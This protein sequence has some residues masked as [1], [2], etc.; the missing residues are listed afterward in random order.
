MH[1]ISN[2]L[3]ELLL[4]VV[5]NCE[6]K[7]ANSGVDMVGSFIFLRFLSPA[8]V[9]PQN[10]NLVHESP[11]PEQTRTLII[12][13]KSLQS[14]IT[15]VPFDGSKEQYMTILD[16]ELQIHNSEI[17]ADIWILLSEKVK[18]KYEIENPILGIQQY[19][20]SVSKF[21]YYYSSKI[22]ESI[23]NE[24]VKNELVS[25]IPDI[26]SKPLYS[27]VSDNS[28][29]DVTSDLDSDCFSPRHSIHDFE[30]IFI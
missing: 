5:R 16:K 18:K 8:I 11:S 24:D 7:H 2:E 21:Y 30:D 29:S 6:T 10:F 28:S 12:V 25:L 13:V 17:Y 15:G 26:V 20:V 19:Y 1:L 14:I 27:P 3:R 22:Y 9:A 23:T 4:V